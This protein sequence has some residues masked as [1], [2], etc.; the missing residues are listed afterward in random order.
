M[1]HYLVILVLLT[2][3]SCAEKIGIKETITTENAHLVT[4]FDENDIESMVTYYFAS[5]IRKDDK[6]KLVLLNAAAWS[7]RMRYSISKHNKWNFVEF[8][9]LGLYEGE[10]GTY[11]KVYFMIEMDGRRDGGEDDVELKKYTGKWVISKV[12]I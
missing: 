10:Y 4:D 12:P 8:K 6:W 11:I 5:R 2:L 7:P 9:N 3:C 1:R